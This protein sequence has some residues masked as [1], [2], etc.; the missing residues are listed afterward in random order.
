MKMKLVLWY[1]KYRKYVWP[2]LLIAAAVV[3]YFAFIR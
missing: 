3:C 2:A 1:V